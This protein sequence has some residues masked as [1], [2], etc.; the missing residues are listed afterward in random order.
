M[1]V[2]KIDKESSVSVL[3]P[4]I[5]GLIIS[6]K[7]IE[8]LFYIVC[9]F[10]FV[11]LGGLSNGSDTQPYCLL[12]S[13]P[14]SFFFIIKNSLKINLNAIFLYITIGIGIII[15]IFIPAI[16][17]INISSCFR[18]IATYIGMICISYVSY[19]LCKMKKN[20][21]EKLIKIII[22]IWGM[23]GIIQLFFFRN[24][25]YRIVANPRTSDNRGV[26]SLAS[27]P[28]Y[29]GAVCVLMLLLVFDFKK[30]KFFYQ[31]N[32]LVQI[33]FIAKSSVSVVYLLCFCSLYLIY[34]LYKR[35]AKHIFVL[36]CILTVAF[37]ILYRVVGNT[38]NG[39]RITMFAEILFKSENLNKALKMI[40]SEKSV[41]I[42]WNDIIFCLKGFAEYLGLP[43]GFATR[44]ISS[45]YGSVIYTM[46]W[47]GV[48]C[49]IQIYFIVKKA[50]IGQK[51][52]ETKVL[53]LFI[54][55]IMFSNIQLA[56][57]IFPFMVGYYLYR[58]NNYIS[59]NE[60]FVQK[61]RIMIKDIL[62]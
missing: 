20:Y 3:M 8:I 15:G 26:I 21:N 58:G 30:N 29:Y 25:A 54:T 49:I 38:G 28:S 7:I 13:V 31:I 39:Q 42:R 53:P 12:I 47:I 50:Y 4:F 61:L 10:P 14:L 35:N 51:K 56:N 45:G 43:H 6:M 40:L 36:A 1:S 32:L 18:Y 5:E 23:V 55:I 41:S 52:Y 37:L 22:N 17:G 57:P 19:S 34:S 59:W 48:L 16:Y 46:G 27:E 33:L 62:R 9:F 24:F 11:V 60:D 2:C 44:I